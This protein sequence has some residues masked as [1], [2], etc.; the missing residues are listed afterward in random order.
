VPIT[1]F[2]LQCPKPGQFSE[3]VHQASTF[4]PAIYGNPEYFNAE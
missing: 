4:R 1:S 3:P 2:A